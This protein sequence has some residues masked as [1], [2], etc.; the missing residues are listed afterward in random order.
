MATGVRQRHGRGCKGTAL[1]VPVGGVRLQQARRAR[2]S[3][4]RS[5]RTP[6][7]R[8]GATTPDGGPQADLRAPTL[9]TVEQAAEAWLQGARKGLIRNR[10]GDPY[11]PATIRA[12]ETAL[13]LRVLPEIGTSG[14]RRSRGPTCRTSSTGCSRPASSASTIG[15][16]LLPLR[17]IYKRALARPETG[18]AVNP[19]SGLEMPAVRGGRDRI[20]PP[21]ECA[22]CSRRSGRRTGRCGRPRC[23]RAAPRRADGAARRGRGPGSRRDP[24][25]PR[26][27]CGRGRDRH[28]V[29]QG[30][31]RPDRPRSSATTSTSTCLASAG[32]TASCSASQPTGRS[33]ITRCENTPAGVGL[34]TGRQGEMVPSGSREPPLE[35]ITLHECRHTFASLMIAAGRQREGPH[36]RTWAT[37]ASRSRSTATAT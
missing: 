10:S 1:Q 19:T 24:R 13:R 29:R 32:R 18:I 4:R 6:R 25:A 34:A 12:Y 3:A 37:R 20:A 11:K 2:R 33:T 23:T 28:E 5:R 36:R 21:E 35:P 9:T 7:R 31:A 30:P 26:L 8:R 16:T 17:A 15:V 27:G 14:Y 22:G